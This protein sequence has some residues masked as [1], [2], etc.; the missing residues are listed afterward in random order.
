MRRALV[1][2]RARRFVV[3]VPTQ[4]LK[5]QWAQAAEQ[6]DL[7]L[8]PDWSAGYGALPSDVHGV[9][10]TYQQVAANPGAL[11]ALVPGALAVLD[12]IHH[13]GESRAWGDG[14]RFAF[15]HAARRLSLSGTPFR[16]D[17]NPIPFVRYDG[18]LAEA[19][20]EYGYGEAL[21]DRARR[22]PGLLPAHQGAHGVDGA[23]RPGLRGD[24]RRPADARAGQ[25]A[26][27][28]RAGRRGR[29]AGRG[30]RAGARAA[31]APARRATRAPRAW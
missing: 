29:L 23:R 2:R 25:P 14:V 13:A 21:K 20:Y 22:A 8:D 3:V 10:V 16:S 7:H 12:E 18:D 30:A 28:H 19:D 5:N 27:A 24:V 15:E 26:A 11:R 6:M 4:H 17:Q 1:A 9:A 31:A